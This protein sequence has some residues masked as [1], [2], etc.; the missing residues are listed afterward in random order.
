MSED[1][2]TPEEVWGMMNKSIAQYHIY[3][4]I[5]QCDDA[6]R[7]YAKMGISGTRHDMEHKMMREE[8]LVALKRL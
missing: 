4:R 5:I 7:Q 3:G 2:P 1:S 6:I 8:Y